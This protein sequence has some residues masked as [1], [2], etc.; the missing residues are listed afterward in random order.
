MPLACSILARRSATIGT[1]GFSSFCLFLVRRW[2]VDAVAAD[3]RS[4]CCRPDAEPRRSFRFVAIAEWCG[5]EPN[6]RFLGVPSPLWQAA[7]AVDL[8]DGLLGEFGDD[9]NRRPNS[10]YAGYERR[11]W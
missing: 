3:T 9:P 6:Y 10:R 4:P 11:G 1:A 7:T 2:N 8:I 5:G